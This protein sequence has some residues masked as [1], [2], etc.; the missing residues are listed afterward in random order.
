MNKSIYLFHLDLLTLASRIYEEK[1]KRSSVFWASRWPKNN[2]PDWRNTYG[3]TNLPRT[4]RLI[5]KSVRNWD[6]WTIVDI[7]FVKVLLSFNIMQTLSYNCDCYYL[8]GKTGDW[9]NHF[10][11]ELNTRINQWIEAN[12]KGT[13]LTFVTELDQQDWF[14]R[15][16]FCTSHHCLMY[17]CFHRDW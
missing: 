6:S 5:T 8:S 3:S 15:R 7:L 17:L 14:S 2:W 12:L 10:S 16:N 13:D 11:P 1:S 4:K 9:K